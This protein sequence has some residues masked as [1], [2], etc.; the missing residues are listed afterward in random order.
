MVVQ[1]ELHYELACMVAQN[2]SGQWTGLLKCVSSD[3]HMRKSAAG[4]Y[5]GAAMLQNL[6]GLTC[7]SQCA[8]K[9]AQ[10]NLVRL[11]RLVKVQHPLQLTA[12]LSPLACLN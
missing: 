4:S 5:C 12:A 7:A 10:R 11:V 6:R 2:A 1:P 8:W 3:R 9:L